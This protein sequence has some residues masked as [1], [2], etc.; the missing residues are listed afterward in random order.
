MCYGNP[1]FCDLVILKLYEGFKLRPISLPSS[2]ISFKDFP[3]HM[4]ANIK[5]SEQFDNTP[6]WQFNFLNDPQYYK[7]FSKI[8]SQF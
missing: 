5:I 4:N 3:T 6:V 7:E 1:E 8:L 2:S